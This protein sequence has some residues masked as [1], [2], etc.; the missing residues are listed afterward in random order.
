MRSTKHEKIKCA[1]GFNAFHGDP[2]DQSS[3]FSI[4]TENEIWVSMGEW[5]GDRPMVSFLLDAVPCWAFRAEIA[6]VMRNYS[7]DRGNVA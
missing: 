6:R 5:N 1:V 4:T 2:G 7:P 3:P